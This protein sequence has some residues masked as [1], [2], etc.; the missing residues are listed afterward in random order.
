M[1]NRTPEEAAFL[2]LAGFE[3][4]ECGKS[5]RETTVP[6]PGEPGHKPHLPDAGYSGFVCCRTAHCPYCGSPYQAR[7]PHLLA[8]KTAYSEWEVSGTRV[9]GFEP[10]VKVADATEPKHLLQAPIPL[11]EEVFGERYPFVARHYGPMLGEK[12]SGA[13][14][15]AELLAPYE[16]DDEQAFRRKKRGWRHVIFSRDAEEVRLAVRDEIV[17]LRKLFAKLDRRFQPDIALSAHLIQAS[18]GAWHRRYRLRFTTDGRHLILFDKLGVT[19]VSVADGLVCGTIPHVTGARGH[20]GRVYIS[21]IG[22]TL[23][24]GYR[25]FTEES[26]RYFIVS[27][28]MTTGSEEFTD[29]DST[30]LTGED[31]L[32]SGDVPIKLEEEAG[33]IKVR[34]SHDFMRMEVSRQG[35]SG[36]ISTLA[37]REPITDYA[38]SPAGNAIATVI[39]D[40]IVIW[41]V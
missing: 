22:E 18:R 8:Y 28:N 39:A 21:Q 36:T 33:P 35:E 30:T 16:H 12:P 9:G 25:N 27:R 15:I 14:M 20:I 32:L 26:G 5:L 23:R 7:C 31:I 1:I 29:G 40:H 10:G 34:L 6:Q 3:C 2:A 37:C 17:T 11:M 41:K 38:L 19:V 4:S 13:R 24:Y